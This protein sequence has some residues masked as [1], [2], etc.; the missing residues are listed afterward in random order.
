MV[1]RSVLHRPIVRRRPVLHRLL[2]RRRL[3]CHSVGFVS[4][5]LHHGLG[6]ALSGAGFGAARP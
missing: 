6:V 2:R 4:G 5:V 3:R 1:R